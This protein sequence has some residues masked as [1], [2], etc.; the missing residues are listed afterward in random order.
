M[1]KEAKHRA[2]V[3]YEKEFRNIK[4][5]LASK[6]LELNHRIEDELKHIK[7]DRNEIENI[8]VE[9]SS[10]KEGLQIQKKIL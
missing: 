3:D 8:K 9:V 7:K 2:K 5:E 10:L 1:L 6:E 4:K